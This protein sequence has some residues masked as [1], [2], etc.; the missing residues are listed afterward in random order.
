MKNV[1][2]HWLFFNE[3]ILSIEM[4]MYLFNFRFYVKSFIV[5]ILNSIFFIG[6]IEKEIKNLANI[7]VLDL[8]NKDEK[9]GKGENNVESS[10]PKLATKQYLGI[11]P[12]Q[13]LTE[14][15]VNKKVMT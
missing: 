4:N 7:F 14:P 2:I 5:L 9:D 6:I 3:I 11:K 1:F 8:N 13:L 12:L 10:K 15:K